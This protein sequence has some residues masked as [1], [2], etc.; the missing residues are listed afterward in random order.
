MRK[1]V[2]GSIGA[3]LL[4]VS[5]LAQET[6]PAPE[7]ELTLP[8]V[9]GSEPDEAHLEP[10]PADRDDVLEAVV[11]G[12]QTDW[13]LP[14]LGSSLREE[15]EERE[16]DQRIELGFVPLYDPEEQDPTVDFLTPEVDVMRGVGMIKLIE[17]RF[18]RRSGPD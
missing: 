11:T 1:A 7:P 18:G 6:S 2:A 14:D 3:S 17:L 8:P 12:G 13:R 4:L 9:I 10:P 16:P 5:A 15:R